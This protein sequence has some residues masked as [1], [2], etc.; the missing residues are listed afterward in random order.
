MK[1]KKETRL[2]KRN[3]GDLLFDVFNYTLLGIITVLVLYPLYFIVIASFSDPDAINTGQVVL[4]PKGFNTLG[5][6]KI[7]ENEKIWRAY[8]NTIFYTIVGTT[9]NIVLTMLFAYPLSR[10]DFSGR[11][12]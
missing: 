5:Y 8:G 7:F 12:L 9:I 11:N 6:Q 3:R 4:W 2:F 1:R 10:K